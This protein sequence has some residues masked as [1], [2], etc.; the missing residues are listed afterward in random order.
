MQN[1]PDFIYNN[2]AMF[3]YFSDLFNLDRIKA[4]NRQNVQANSGKKQPLR[5]AAL[6]AALNGMK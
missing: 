6:A 2:S 3:L 4:N 5:G 1:I